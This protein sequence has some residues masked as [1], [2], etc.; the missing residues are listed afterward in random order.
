MTAL[1][2]LENREASLSELCELLSGSSS[3]EKPLSKSGL[4]HRLKKLSKMA[5]ELRLQAANA[6]NDR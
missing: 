4:N 5:E 6:Q 2:R 1:L 3:G